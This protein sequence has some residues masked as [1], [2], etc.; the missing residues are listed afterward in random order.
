[1]MSKLKGTIES[2]LIIGEYDQGDICHIEYDELYNLNAELTRLTTEN[3][4]LRAALVSS[5]LNA[6]IIVGDSPCD[7]FKTGINT[8]RDAVK[9]IGH[10]IDMAY[11]ARYNHDNIDIDEVK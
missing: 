9:G 3:H 7:A 2:C 8:L 1:M 10:D 4:R 11:I 6:S 5:E